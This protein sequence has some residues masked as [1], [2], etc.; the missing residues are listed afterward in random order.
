M[1]LDVAHAVRADVVAERPVGRRRF[2][3]ADVGA[4][5]VDHV[6]A[7]ADDLAVLRQCELARADAVGL[8]AGTDQVLRPVLD[9]LHRTPGAHRQ[10]AD[11]GHVREQRRLDPE[12]A[13]D[14]PGTITRTLASGIRSERASTGSSVIGPMKFAHI[15][16]TPAAG[17]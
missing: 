6:S 8:V 2:R 9:P 7:E 11:D 14:V 12:A 1:E 17:S 15:V 13:S 3:G 10:Q 16:R 4:E 5:V